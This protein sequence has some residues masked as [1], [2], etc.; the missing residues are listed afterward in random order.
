MFLTELKNT[1]TQKRFVDEGKMKTTEE[2]QELIRYGEREDMIN[3]KL[4]KKQKG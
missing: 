4:A 1:G 2:L 3:E